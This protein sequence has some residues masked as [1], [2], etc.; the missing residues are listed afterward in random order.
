M[1][2]RCD[3]IPTSED[4]PVSCC[5]SARMQITARYG[6]TPTSPAP[7]PPLP[8]GAV[9][10]RYA[11]GADMALRGPAS[12]RIYRVGRGNRALRA[13]PRDAQALIATGLFVAA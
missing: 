6:A 2:R 13:D 12:G 3:R 8:E 4:E 10:L 5:G 1:F 9:P 11:G 7:Q